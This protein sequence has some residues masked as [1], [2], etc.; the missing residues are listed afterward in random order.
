M[1][2]LGVTGILLTWK[3]E[4]QLQP[5]TQKEIHI[6][7][8]SFLSIYQIQQIAKI[9]AMHDLQLDSAINRIDIRPEK[10]IAKIRF[11]NHFTEIQVSLQSGK[12]MSVKTRTADIIERIHD[13]S[14]LDFIFNTKNDPSKKVY[15]TLT[16]IGLLVL[17]FSGFWL[18]I[19]PRRIRNKKT[20]IS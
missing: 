3:K 13:G 1:F 7:A 6:D 20:S 14:I 10:G 2:I 15:S 12:I 4:L 8:S 19:N 18:W 11:T 16:S 9:H 17:S 5:P